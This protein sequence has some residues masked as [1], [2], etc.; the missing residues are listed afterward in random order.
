MK[1]CILSLLLLGL[2]FMLHGQQTHTGREA[3]NVYFGFGGGNGFGCEG[4]TGS[5][6]TG[7]FNDH[8]G[9][10]FNT[11]SLYIRAKNQPADYKPGMFDR[12]FGK[13]DRIFMA[14]LMYNHSFPAAM[15]FRC[16]LECGPAIVTYYETI[17]TP[18]PDYDDGFCLFFCPSN[19]NTSKESSGSS[20]G[21]SIRAKLEIP[22]SRYAGIELAA[23]AS[24]NRYRSFAGIEFFMTFGR[25]N[26]MIPKRTK[27]K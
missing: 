15:R 16:G 20:M 5:H 23:F 14:S 2:P 3:G 26:K 17:F 4:L 7:F 21:F 6:L 1:S 10:G 8:S 25:V 19:Y 22:Y 18:N 27:K 11:H 9:L 13:T 24:L 12:E